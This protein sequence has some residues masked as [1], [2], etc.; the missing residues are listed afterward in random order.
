MLPWGGNDGDALAQR[1]GARK[2]P[3][4]QCTDSPPNLTLVAIVAAAVTL[5]QAGHGG[6]RVSG[7]LLCH[8]AG[9]QQAWRQWLLPA[10]PRPLEFG[11]D[12]EPGRCS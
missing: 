7:S 3:G 10:S 1:G 9:L 11:G 8:L 6:R 5:H 4:R 12:D 2:H